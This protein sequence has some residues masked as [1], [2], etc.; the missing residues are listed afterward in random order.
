MV[1]IQWIYTSSCP[2]CPHGVDSDNCTFMCYLAMSISQDFCVYPLCLY[3]Y[4]NFTNLIL[5][6]VL[7]SIDRFISFFFKCNWYLVH[8]IDNV[9]PKLLFCWMIRCKDKGMVVPVFNAKAHGG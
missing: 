2:G 5:F 6:L 1:T 9:S 7:F 4:L 3:T 8:S